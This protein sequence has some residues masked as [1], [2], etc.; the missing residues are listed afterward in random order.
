M[1]LEMTRS[2]FQIEAHLRLTPYVYIYLACDH[3][4]SFAAK[5]IAR[6]AVNL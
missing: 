4:D 3:R 5:A 6:I 1:Q 2:D